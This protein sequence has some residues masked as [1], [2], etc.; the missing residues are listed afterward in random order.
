MSI[1]RMIISISV[2]VLAFFVTRNANAD[3]CVEGCGPNTFWG[4]LLGSVGG[5]SYYFTG[6]CN[7]HDHCYCYARNTYCWTREECDDKFYDDMIDTCLS[8][9]PLDPTC[10][11]LA[12]EAYV[13]VRVGGEKHWNRSN[14]CNDYLD[15]GGQ[16]TCPNYPMSH[17]YVDRSYDDCPRHG[18]Y[19]APFT[20]IFTVFGSQ[21][22]KVASG[23]TV[24]INAGVYLEKKGLSMKGDD[25]T[26]QNSGGE[27]RVKTC[28]E[29]KFKCGAACCEDGL[30]CC[31]S[32]GTCVVDPLECGCASGETL[33]GSVCCSQ[34][35]EECCEPGLCISLDEN[36]P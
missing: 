24:S 5:W 21:E 36:C 1:K 25:V 29:G 28:S 27:V 3:P 31:E 20:D 35:N 7:H 15:K 8:S 4:Q 6:D 22:E 26:I 16:Y 19:G 9:H 12:V 34:T 10:Y 33:C 23:G 17:V 30:I 18:T 32:N 13:A 11:I 14:Q 2:L